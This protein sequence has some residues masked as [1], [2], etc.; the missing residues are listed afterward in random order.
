MFYIQRLLCSYAAGLA[1]EHCLLNSVFC[2][3]LNSRTQEAQQGYRNCLVQENS[4]PEA[5]RKRA[6]ENPEIQQILGDPAMRLI[7]EQMQ[8]DPNALKE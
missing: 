8:K 6:M 2:L 1:F 3:F 7:L 5:V 4:D